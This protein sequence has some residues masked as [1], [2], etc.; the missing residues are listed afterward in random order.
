MR[1][2]KWVAAAAGVVLLVS[3]CG[4]DGGSKESGA[5]ADKGGANAAEAGGGDLDADAVRG[6]IEKAATAAGLAESSDAEPVEEVLR[7][8]MVSWYADPS[9]I[10]SGEKAYDDAI[11]TLNEAGWE[12]QQSQIEDGMKLRMLSKGG[13]NVNTSYSGEFDLPETIYFVATDTGEACEKKFMEEM[14]EM[15]GWE[16]ESP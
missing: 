5:N 12:E 14:E 13:W 10:E 15:E 4:S 6:E 16:T 9:K 3:G 11:A 2:A 8:C 7:D 1:K